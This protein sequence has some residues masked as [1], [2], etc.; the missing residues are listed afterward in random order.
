[1][2][3]NFPY[4]FR[5]MELQIPARFPQDP[6]ARLRLA[7]GHL[8]STFDRVHVLDG[9]VVDNTGLDTVYELLLAVEYHADPKNRSSYQADAAILLAN[10]RRHGVCVLEIDAGAKPNTDLPARLNPFG[11]IT[12]QNQALENGG[13]SN[14]DRAKQLYLRAIRRILA[15]R[16][17]EAGDPVTGGKTSLSDLENGL[18]PTAL[19]YC[20]QCNH[21]QPGHGAD[22][23]IMTAWALGPRDK[24][25]VVARFLPELGL[26]N[27]R[28]AQ[29]WH[30]IAASKA[31]VARARQVARLH[32]LLNRVAALSQVF[33]RLSLDLAD[34]EKRAWEGSQVAP[35]NVTQLRG[36]FNEAK[37]QLG[38][39]AVDVERETDEELREAW[40]ELGRQAR[41]DDER[42]ALL[43]KVRTADQRK[44]WMA[45]LRRK[46][47]L[48]QQS[49][50]SFERIGNRLEAAEAGIAKKVTAELK[51]RLLLDPQLKYDQANRQAKEVYEKR[52]GMKR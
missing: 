49:K 10:L 51:Q 42:L 47:D 39:L 40:T 1:M 5:A 28:R 35:E 48:L 33:H 34:L 12:E 50:E 37:K 46:P 3:S 38:P 27:Q 19:H 22:P 29:L 17:E 8:Q 2:S 21:Y 26:W 9:G 43:E 52:A 6:A 45:E 11:G 25:E 30:D 7:G 13:Y 41:E 23:A 20:F 44:Q 4:G 31:G 18:P 14:A 24:A 32:I 36:K 15:Q 16:L